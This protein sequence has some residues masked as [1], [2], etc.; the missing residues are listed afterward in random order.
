MLAQG[1]LQIQDGNVARNGD[2]VC[3]PLGNTSGVPGMV[4]CPF[5]HCVGKAQG[6]LD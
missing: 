1:Q 6:K 4:L 5:G 3:E 2:G